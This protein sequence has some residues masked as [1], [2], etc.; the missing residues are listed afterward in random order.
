[1]PG[2][3]DLQRLVSVRLRLLVPA[4]NAVQDLLPLLRGLLHRPYGPRRRLGVL[5][6]PL[7]RVVRRVWVGRAGRPLRGR[8]LLPAAD[9]CCDGLPLS[10]GNVLEF[11]IAVRVH[12]VRCLFTWVRGDLS[13]Y[14]VWV[15]V[16]TIPVL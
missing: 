13:R 1:M 15:F 8:V 11:N 9:G 3:I 16:Q 5:S 10:R 7:G 12:P 14:L 4:E 6:L 2:G